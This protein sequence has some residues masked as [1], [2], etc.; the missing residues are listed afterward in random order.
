MKEER[1]GERKKRQN[2]EGKRKER[3]KETKKKIRIKQKRAG[4]KGTF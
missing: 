2:I 4:R 1:L 3:E